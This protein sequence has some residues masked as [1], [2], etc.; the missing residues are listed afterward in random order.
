MRTLPVLASTLLALSLFASPAYARKDPA[1]PVAAWRPSDAEK[2]DNKAGN[3][4][5]V[6]HRYADA[7]ASFRAVLLVEPNCGQ[8]LVGLGRSL[9]E[10]GK[11]ADGLAPL[12]LAA[13]LFPAE[14][15]AQVNYARG[16]LANAKPDEAL[17]AARVALAMKPSNVDAHHVAQAVFRG[18]KDYAGAHG[19]LTTAREVA[20]LPAYDCMDGLTY[21]EE[22]RLDDA[23]KTWETCANV[24]DE[25]LTDPL[26]AALGF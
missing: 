6:Q 5:L 14:L 12:T 4:A 11:P 15:D 7:E 23:K 10:G 21:A 18:K 3:D 19:M 1:P 13:T 25:R 17:A 8:A 22:G 9:V 20:N 26:R 2:V 24:P 16:L